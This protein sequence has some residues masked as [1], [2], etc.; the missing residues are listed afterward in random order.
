FSY[1]GRLQLAWCHRE[2]GQVDEMARWQAEAARR[3]SIPDIEQA[4]NDA[5]A[6]LLEGDLARAETL[7]ER[8]EDLRPFAKQTFVWVPPLRQ[9]IGDVRG[10]PRDLRKLDAAVR[11]SEGVAR[12]RLDAVLGRL[13]A[14]AGQQRRAGELL[15]DAADRGF[16][17]HYAPHWSTTI[18]SCWAEVAVLC[19]DVAAGGVIARWFEPLAHQFVDNGVAVTDTVDRVRA[20]ALLAAGD[21]AGALA[22]GAD[23][24]RRSRIRRTP[25]LLGREL[26]VLA[27]ARQR[28]ELSVADEIDEA[29]VIAERTGARVIDHDIRLFVGRPPSDLSGLT[30]REREVMEHVRYGATNDQ[31]ARALSISAATVRTHLEHVF[32]KLDVSTR[33]AA[34]A[35][36]TEGAART[37]PG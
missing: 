28:S 1:T 27:A 34:V 3:T 31:I 29:T 21:T 8:M 23:A 35:R 6:A 33:T 30:A 10:A 19:S 24:V 17:S 13:L 5:C 22:V 9:A 25:I 26:V 11:R 14:R 32:A 20:L 36:L 37:P 18:G 7:T 15:A 4:S 2:L 16:E 12:F